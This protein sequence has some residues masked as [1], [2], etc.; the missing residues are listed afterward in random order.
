V[1]RGKK[2][3]SNLGHE[4]ALERGEWKAS[5]K[6]RPESEAEIVNSSH[7]P[8]GNCSEFYVTRF[9][10][11]YKILTLHSLAVMASRP[12]LWLYDEIIAP[13]WLHKAQVSRNVHHNAWSEGSLL[14]EQTGFR[15]VRVYSN[16]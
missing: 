1:S 8:S 6:S 13:P 12:F 11:N 4:N 7:G 3:F 9:N 16:F 5:K 10:W 15:C 14:A 2:I